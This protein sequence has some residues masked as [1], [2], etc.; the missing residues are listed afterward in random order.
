MKTLKSTIALFGM[1]LLLSACGEKPHNNDDHDDDHHEGEEVAVPA[2][3][4]SVVQ[5]D[6]L[7]QE[8][9]NK[10]VDLIQ[11]A[12]N[13]DENGEPIDPEDPRFVPATRALVIDYNVLKAY[14]AFIDKEAKDSKTAVKS[15]RIYLGKYPD[16]GSASGK[17]PGSE[18]VFMNPTT[19]FDGGNEASFAI[20]NNSDGTSTA[21]SVGSVLGTS[22]LSGKANLV[23]KQTGPIQSLALDDL[24]QI[25][26]PYSDK[27]DY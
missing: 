9:G 7:Y 19:I 12:Q 27:E 26:P 13:V 1:L 11:N 14:I 23:L 24:G 25:P 18:T 3:I 21:V 4:I 10:R 5:A 20:Q 16:G 15:M 6:T 2:N 8:Y 17:R 22:Q